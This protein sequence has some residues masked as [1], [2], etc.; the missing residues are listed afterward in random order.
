[1]YRY[2]N[3]TAEKN[4]VTIY[5]RGTHAATYYIIRARTGKYYY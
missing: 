3:E 2:N 5:A 1:M 4:S